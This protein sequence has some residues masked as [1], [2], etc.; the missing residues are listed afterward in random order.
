MADQYPVAQ[1]DKPQGNEA[2]N[3]QTWKIIQAV[4]GWIIP[5]LVSILIAYASWSAVQIMALREWK[6]RMDGTVM[7]KDGATALEQKIRD[8]TEAIKTDLT[9]LKADLKIL[10]NNLENR[11][12]PDWVMQVIRDNTDRIKRLE[13]SGVSPPK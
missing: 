5:P 8:S 9:G 3:M 10:N 13:Q 6:S 2:A 12:P 7:D 11:P 1:G 4:A